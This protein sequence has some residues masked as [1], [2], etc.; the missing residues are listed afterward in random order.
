[1]PL[2][3]PRS[4]ESEK[5]FISRCMGKQ[6]MVDEF[7][8]QKKRSAVCYKQYREERAVKSARK[9]AGLDKD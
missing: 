6:S 5:E 2:P 9:A 4:D 7:P 1:M 3:K 8:D